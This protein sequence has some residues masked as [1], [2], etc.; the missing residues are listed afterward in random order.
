MIMH[1]LNLP[2]SAN[3]NMKNKSNINTSRIG[4]K[5][6]KMSRI[7]LSIEIVTHSIITRFVY[8]LQNNY[9]YL[10]TPSMS[11]L[12]MKKIGLRARV[13]CMW[14]SCRARTVMASNNI[15]IRMSVCKPYK[16]C[17]SYRSTPLLELFSLSYI[18]YGCF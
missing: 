9:L 8:W 4:F 12:S 13:T 5:D 15:A 16:L 14:Y 6:F 11:R 7:S 18:E 2:R 17:L 3:I 1:T 10:R